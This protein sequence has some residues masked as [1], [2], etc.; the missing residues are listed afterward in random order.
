[1]F[2]SKYKDKLIKIYKTVYGGVTDIIKN[3]EEL[4]ADFNNKSILTEISLSLVAIACDFMEQSNIDPTSFF[5]NAY[6]ILDDS[7][8][9]YNASLPKPISYEDHANDL[10]AINKKSDKF[11]N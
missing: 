2:D 8:A 9:R 1:M 7:F 4:N 10:P 6:Y 5:N 3:N 11:I